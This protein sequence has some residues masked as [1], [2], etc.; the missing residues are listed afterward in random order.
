MVRNKDGGIRLG[1][2]I[3]GLNEAVI[4][5]SFPL[6]HTE[7]LLNSLINAT[8]F[9]KL[10]LASTYH[11]VLLHPKSRD[12]TAFMTHDKLF[13]VKRVCFGLASPPQPFNS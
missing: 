8:M 4:T 7:E 1:V 11:Q 12:F 6:P 10:D 2:D 13:H 9:S 5:D 3:R